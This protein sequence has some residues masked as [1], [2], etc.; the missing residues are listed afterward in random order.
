MAAELTGALKAA[1]LGS[2]EIAGGNSRHEPDG[3]FVDVSVSVDVL[4]R[5]D[6]ARGVSLLSGARWVR[7]GCEDAGA[8]DPD[9]C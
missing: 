9:A 1:G 7:T 5:D 3:R 2:A 8:T 4:V 6:L